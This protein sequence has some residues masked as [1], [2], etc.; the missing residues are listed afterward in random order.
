[1]KVAYLFPFTL[2]LLI[3]CDLRSRNRR[4]ADAIV[5]KMPATT[6]MNV[7]KQNYRLTIPKGWTTEHRTVYGIDY[8][9]LLA[10]KNDD[11][12]NTS[13]NVITEDMQNLPLEEFTTKTIESVSNAIP[14]A[15]NFVQG[16]ITANALK[17]RWYSYTMEPQ[18]LKAVLV[19]Y[20]FPK[21]GTAYVI[22]AGTVPRNASR[23][24]SLFDSVAESLEFIEPLPNKKAPND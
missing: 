14:S 5:S 4:A 17:G 1:M 2:V 18:G 22:T 12:P 15:S 24:R 19:S 11:D 21:N 13:L 23:Y 8:Y 20:I 16:E 9:Y 10:P 6:N 3:A 7:G